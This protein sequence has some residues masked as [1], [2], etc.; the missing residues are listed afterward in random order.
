[1]TNEAFYRECARLLGTSYDCVPFPFRKRTRWNNRTAG[2]GRFPGHGII[3]VFGDEVQVA[4]TCPK[5]TMVG[6]KDEVLDRL[7]SF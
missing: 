6:S 4:L 2:S 1:M 7:A 5:L 3:R